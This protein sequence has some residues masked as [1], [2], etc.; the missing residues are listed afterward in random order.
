MDDNLTLGRCGRRA[1]HCQELLQ[2]LSFPGKGYSP[3]WQKKIRCA[4]EKGGFIRAR[5][6]ILK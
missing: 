3:A 2:T 1:G 4:A 6:G 5:Y